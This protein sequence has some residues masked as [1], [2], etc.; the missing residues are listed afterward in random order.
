MSH[1]FYISLS[2]GLT[3]LIVI[4]LIGWVM[5]DGRARSREL[6]EL[7]ASGIRRRASAKLK[8]GETA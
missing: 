5:L 8:A 2:Y 4:A 6:K 1:A 3:G 7:E